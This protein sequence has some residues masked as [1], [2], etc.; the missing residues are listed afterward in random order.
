MVLRLLLGIGLRDP[1]RRGVVVALS[2]IRCFRWFI[3]FHVHKALSYSRFAI[4]ELGA[5]S[6]SRGGRLRL[7]IVP[8]VVTGGLRH[9]FGVLTARLQGQLRRGG[10]G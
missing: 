9:V 10:R 1:L 6:R 4:R 7:L 5:N 2:A 3:N 8:L